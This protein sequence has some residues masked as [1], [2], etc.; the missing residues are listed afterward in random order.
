MWGKNDPTP[1]LGSTTHGLPA[2][3]V[4]AAI[5]KMLVY[6]GCRAYLLTTICRPA[7]VGV[8]RR[9]HLRDSRE[10]LRDWI[11]RYSGESVM[12]TSTLK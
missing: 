11:V 2:A 1:L 6:C 12:A 4:L 3:N 8:L 5:S 7:F 9:L 10:L